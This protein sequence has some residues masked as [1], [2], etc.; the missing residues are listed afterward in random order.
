VLAGLLAEL[1]AERGQYY[2]RG[3]WPAVDELPAAGTL[4][5]ARYG[6]KP[7]KPGNTAPQITSTCTD[8]GVAAVAVVTRAAIPGRGGR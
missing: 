8:D 6:G 4:E 3:P 7:G 1:L 2:V 5:S